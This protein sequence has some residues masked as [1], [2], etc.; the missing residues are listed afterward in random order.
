M[1]P[2]FLAHAAAFR[3]WLER[4]DATAAEEWVGFYRKDSGRTG[5]TYPEALD[6]ALCL[7]WIDGIRRKTGH[8]R[9]TNRF[10]PRKKGSSW[11]LVN[12]APATRLSATGR[13]HAAGLAAFAARRP[14]KT[15]IYSFERATVTELPPPYLRICKRDRQA[16]AHFAAQP[17]GYR[18]LAIH[19]VTSAKQAATRERRL[20]RLI[21]AAAAG[22]RITA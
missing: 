5:L 4:H 11:S 21:A 16:W 8:D 7:G 18:R 1:K 19:Y 22:R 20:R 13:M 15:G 2:E 9:Y 6:A 12:V 17:P 3:S 14:E 10:T